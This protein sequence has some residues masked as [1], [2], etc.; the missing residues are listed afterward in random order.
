MYVACFEVCFSI[1]VIYKTLPT[2]L[3]SSML[4][5][6]PVSFKIKTYASRV[7]AVSAPELQN[8][9]S[10]NIRSCENLS[11]FKHK[12]KTY[13]FRN[14]CFSH[15]EDLL[16]FI[17][18][19]FKFILINI[20]FNSNFFTLLS[21]QIIT[22]VLL[23]LIIIIQRCVSPRLISGSLQYFSYVSLAYFLFRKLVNN[24]FAFQKHCSAAWKNKFRFY[25]HI[26]FIS[27]AVS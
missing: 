19:L 4:N 2:P 23:L 22:N 10:D 24:D 14:Y 7:F 17:C 3:S 15:Q 18:V 26:F 25:A 20:Y 5:L 8:K 12:L 16:D 9:L 6:N 27:S 1:P 11:L 13:L 21:A